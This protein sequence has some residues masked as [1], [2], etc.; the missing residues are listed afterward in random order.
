MANI[1]STLDDGHLTLIVDGDFTYYD[2][3][4]FMQVCEQYDTKLESITF[5]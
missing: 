1:D 2:K 5:D 4:A 3:S